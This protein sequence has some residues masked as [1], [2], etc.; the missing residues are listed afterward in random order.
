MAITV[1]AVYEDGVLKPTHPLPLQEH[2][3]VR[4]Q[5]ETVPEAVRRVRQSAGL[6]RCSDPALIEW[7]ARDPELDYPSSEES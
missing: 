6:I 5:I 3:K 2:E 7:A 4:I 1:E